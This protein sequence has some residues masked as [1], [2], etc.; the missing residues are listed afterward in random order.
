MMGK[1]GDYSSGEM[2]C[3]TIKEKKIAVKLYRDD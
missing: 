3:Q 2:A 1:K